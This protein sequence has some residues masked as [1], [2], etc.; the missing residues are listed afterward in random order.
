MGMLKLIREDYH[1]HDAKWLNPALWAILTYRYGVWSLTIKPSWLQW[2][3]SKVYGLLI[4]VVLITSGIRLYREV[5]VGKAL[6]LIH[7]GNIS[8]H[9]RTVIGDYCGIQQD[10]TLGTNMERG[11][12]PIIGN[13]VYIGRGATVLG[14]VVIGDGARIA[15]NS[16]VITDVPPHATAIGV[17]ARII[18]YTGRPENGS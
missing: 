12:A 4:F 13:N 9:P 7:S 16:L 1:R 18:K 2:I 17:P 3:A 15:A 11:G 10:V 8:I 6:H 14:E 5:T